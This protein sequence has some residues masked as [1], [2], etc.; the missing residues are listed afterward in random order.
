MRMRILVLGGTWFLGR[1]VVA[2]GLRR[3]WEVT[4]FNRGLS[5]ADVPGVRPVRGDRGRVADLRRLASDGPWDAVIDSS[6]ADLDPAAVAAGAEALEPVA[7]RY[8]F[9]SSV[10][11]YR[12]WPAE[13]LTESSELF[14]PA[15]T[16][17]GPRKAA[18]ERAVGD[19]FGT[20]R[21]AV[22]RPGVI[23]GPG[24][25]V[26][27]LPWWLH[28][29]H[30]GGPMLAPGSPGRTIQPVDVRD[31]AAFALRLAG[32]AGPV[33]GAYNVVAP[34][35]RETM[36]GLLHDCVTVTGRRAEPRWVASEVLLA[37]GVRPWTEL[38]LWRA[39][40]GGWEVASD[41]AQAAGLMCRP[42][43]ETVMD[44]WAWLNGGGLPVDHPR[45][46]QPGIDPA[47]EA[48]ILASPGGAG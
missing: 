21:T 20:G 45:R 47:K 37:H 28:R 29:A 3:G 43:A 4:T 46:A 32:A 9:V 38:P 10:N 34:I 22:L 41:A 6:A 23:L 19:R 30:R 16:G 17:Y 24:E 40:D 25:Y 2:E 18:A 44:T 27:R 33:G 7:G 14:A 26:G 15:G 12:G 8:V 48:A 35:G 36:G 5:G 42:L 13:P 39:I 1:A 31:V 11:A